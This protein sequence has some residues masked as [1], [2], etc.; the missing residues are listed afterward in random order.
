MSAVWMLTKE[1]LELPPSEARDMFNPFWIQD[2]M[3][4]RLT[5]SQ[6]GHICVCCHVVRT[7]QNIEES[8]PTFQMLDKVENTAPGQAP[9]P[10]CTQQV[11]LAGLL[12]PS[13]GFHWTLTLSWGLLWPSSW[14][15]PMQITLSGST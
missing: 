8:C 6:A 2:R 3:L 4:W 13:K 5:L 7:G 14:V 11:D 1:S 12:I 15:P 9:V 10:G